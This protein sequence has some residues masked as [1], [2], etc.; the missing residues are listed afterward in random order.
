ME[1]QTIGR[2][3]IRRLLGRGGMATVYLALD[4]R[5]QREVAVKVLPRAYLNDP[6]FRARFERE[7]QTI[8]ALEHPAIVPVHDFG[9]EEGR[10]YLVMAY[11]T[12]GSL[13]DHLQN[14]A[15]SPRDAARVLRRIGAALDQAHRVGIVHRDL[16]PANILFDRYDNAYLSD[17]GIVKLAQATS[18][19]T[20]EA[21]IGTPSYMSPEQAR[22]DDDLDGRSDIYALGAILYTM[23]SG[24]VP[25]EAETP[26]GVLV[27]HISA[28]LP[29]LAQHAPHLAPYDP[30]IQKAMAKSPRDRYATA[31][32]LV[33]DLDRVIGG[34][35]ALA[36]AAA[37]TQDTADGPVGSQQDTSTGTRRR[38]AP[39]M[40]ALG[41][42]F[43]IACIAGVAVATNAL[44][45]LF[46]ESTPGPGQAT[47]T[48]DAIVVQNPGAATSATATL[49]ATPTSTTTPTPMA[50]EV[51]PLTVAPQ[52]TTTPTD[53]PR[54][55]ASATPRLRNGPI[56]FDSAEDIYIMN[57]DGSG[58]QQLTDTP[59][60]DDEADVSSDGRFI[61]FETQSGNERVIMIMGINGQS[62][63]ELVPG[64]LPDWS[65]DDRFIAFE[66]GF[67]Q[68]IYVVEVATGEVRQITSTLGHSRAPSWS[69][70][71]QQIAFMT[72]VGNNWQ[73]AV[74][75]VDTGQHSVITG[76]SPSK[77]F[78]VWSP[79]G[80]LIAYNTL[81]SSGA[82][83]HI[84]VIEPSGDASRRLT[85]E[86]Q[87]GRPA[88]SPD[89]EY[90]LFNSNRSGSWLVYRMD[91]DGSNQIV[92][93]GASGDAQRADWGPAWR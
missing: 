72:E 34:Q 81:R 17:F 10:L 24:A 46:G 45:F 64:R 75:D 79:D 29:T 13:A 37:E 23:L 43:V 53:T 39:W 18:N 59:A 69:P 47:A 2:Y 89:G 85:S 3:E 20:G 56:V 48:P 90:I 58:L 82:I 76:G 83:D 67:P 55:T 5:F 11:M 41:G 33:L 9:D 19:L 6:L 42:L 78:P 4:P 52:A 26:V 35:A 25:Y 93:T 38:I 28:P 8:A 60:R 40:L 86:G 73:L 54:P 77:R 30:V 71:G 80:R 14:G 31:N 16:K 27:K 15:M 50:A 74:V 92:L 1:R 57:P 88:W 70:D 63:R 49:T 65:P 44:P 61:A 32:D 68:Q 66:T 22:G 36:E 12:G 51:D 84:W 21:V 7:A 87:N 91:R 62:P